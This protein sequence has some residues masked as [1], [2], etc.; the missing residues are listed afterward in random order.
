MSDQPWIYYIRLTGAQ[1]R[2]IV[3]TPVQLLWDQ[4]EIRN[5]AGGC[6]RDSGGG[7]F[8]TNG[9][10]RA[11][12]TCAA[13]FRDHCGFDIADFNTLPERAVNDHGSSAFD[14]MIPRPPPFRAGS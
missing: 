9:G 6:Y 8:Y 5:V 11:C 3:R 4:Q 13:K 14:G 7:G 1:N 12:T 10:G 2:E